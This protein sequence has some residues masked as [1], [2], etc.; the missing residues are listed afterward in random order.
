[1]ILDCISTSDSSE[2]TKN[3]MT[4]TTL[5]KIL[6]WRCNDRFNE[7]F[8]GTKEECEA[9]LKKEFLDGHAEWMED[10]Q[11]YSSLCD[12]CSYKEYN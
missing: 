8:E 5:V 10:E 9:Y 3:T 2:L 1:M 11:V 6:C 7:M 4:T 12:P